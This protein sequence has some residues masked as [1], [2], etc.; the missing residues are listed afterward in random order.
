MATGE[1]Q[2]NRYGKL[3]KINGEANK[4]KNIH[5]KEVLKTYLLLQMQ[6]MSN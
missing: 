5:C 1:N 3:D 4:E 6:D 2:T